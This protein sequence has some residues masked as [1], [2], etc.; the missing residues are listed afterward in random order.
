[1]GKQYEGGKADN[2]HQKSVRVV[3]E[4]LFYLKEYVAVFFCR[5]LHK[6][7]SYI[8]SMSLELHKKSPY[9]SFFWSLVQTVAVV[10][11]FI[12]ILMLVTVPYVVRP[13][14]GDIKE[15]RTVGSVE[16]RTRMYQD[17]R[18]RRDYM[19][20]RM[21]EGQLKRDPALQAVRDNVLSALSTLRA[22]SCNETLRKEYVKSIS[23]FLTM[24][25]LPGRGI[26]QKSAIEVYDWEG[27]TFSSTKFLNDQVLLRII[28]EDVIAYIDGKDF[29]KSQRLLAKNT[30]RHRRYLE[31]CDR[32]HP[33]GVIKRWID[34]LIQSYWQLPTLQP[35]GFLSSSKLSKARFQQISPVAIADEDERFSSGSNDQ[36]GTDMEQYLLRHEDGANGS[37]ED[38]LIDSDQADER[39][40]DDYDHRIDWR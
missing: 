2:E 5:D 29:S 37:H 21:E 6:C 17:Y 11:G 31:S 33:D 25:P 28:R 14:V 12:I 32:F 23:T 1:M 27:L 10:I 38:R 40:P 39:L 4:Q 16:A 13:G 18:A 26:P 36:G 3:I 19:E 15:G 34:D 24:H 8:G 20:Q 35:L 7:K 9:V 30:P 22:D